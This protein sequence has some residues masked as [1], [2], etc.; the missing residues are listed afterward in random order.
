MPHFVSPAIMAALPPTMARRRYYWIAVSCL[1]LAMGTIASYSSLAHAD[2]VDF[3]DQY[4][5]TQ[6]PHVLEGLS[7]STVKWALTAT[8]AQ[9][10]HPLTWLSHALD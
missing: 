2:F 3:D 5:V 10:W 1:A 9:N 7:W 4:Y 6:N 8:E